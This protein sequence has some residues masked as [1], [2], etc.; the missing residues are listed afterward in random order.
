VEPIP[1]RRGLAMALIVVSGFSGFL[2]G[3]ILLVAGAITHVNGLEG[4]GAILV[5]VA[6]VALLALGK[7]SGRSRSGQVPEVARVLGLQFSQADPFGL[8]T[9]GLPFDVFHQRS[10]EVRNVMWGE[11]GG[12]PV[13]GFDLRYQERQSVAEGPGEEWI[14]TNW[15]FTGLAPVPANCPPLRLGRYVQ[16]TEK[17]A[18]VLF[19]SIEFNEKVKVLC[20]DAYFATALIDAR[21][22]AFLLDEASELVSVEVNG[23]HVLAGLGEDSGPYMAELLIQL[24]RFVE[25]VP[26]VV[27]SLYTLDTD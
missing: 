21:M 26:S 4:I 11:V 3:T 23:P 10:V 7:W 19:E 1:R 5:L 20:T 2:A 27:R 12:V 8:A 24:S 14:F 15:Q 25:H 9:A 13:Q 18:R 22:M 17:T 6:I 16:P